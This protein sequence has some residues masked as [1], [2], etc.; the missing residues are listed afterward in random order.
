M[1]RERPK[2]TR[3][4]KLRHEKYLI[5]HSVLIGYAYFLHRIKA[6]RWGSVSDVQIDVKIFG[7]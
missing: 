2:H 3:G 5:S 7:R 6:I 4:Q 1:A